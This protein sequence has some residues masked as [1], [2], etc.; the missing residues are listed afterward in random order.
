MEVTDVWDLDG[1][2]A[3]A[4]EEARSGRQE[5]SQAQERAHDLLRRAA[6]RLTRTVGLPTRD[7]ADVLGVSHQRLQQIVKA[8]VGPKGRPGR[9]N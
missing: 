4:L 5:A 7:A 2:T 9:S 1:D 8:D 3:T 6:V